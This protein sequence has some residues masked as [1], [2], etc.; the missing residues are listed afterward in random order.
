MHVDYN[1]KVFGLYLK[2]LRFRKTAI[3]IYKNC[4]TAT[5]TAFDG[6]TSKFKSFN[7]GRLQLLIF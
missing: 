3:F 7:T 2:V 4:D 1:F 5:L 6:N